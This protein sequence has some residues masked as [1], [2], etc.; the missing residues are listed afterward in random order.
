[1]QRD[2]C[3]AS[4]SGGAH[5]EPHSIAGLQW[6]VP[7]GREPHMLWV[8][9]TEDS[10]ALTQL[11]MTFSARKWSFYDPATRESPAGV[12]ASVSRALMR[13]YYLV[14]KA[15][16]AAI[17]GIL[18]GTLGVAGYL[19]VIDRLRA[20]ATA[21]GKK[22]YTMLMGKPSPTKLANFAEARPRGKG[23][24]EGLLRC[25][26]G[27]GSVSEREW[28]CVRAG[29]GLGAR[30]GRAGADIGLQGVSGAHRYAF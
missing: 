11:L 2:A 18:V 30:G 14:E 12:P 25:G 26:C 20:L 7:G 21:A 10:T 5:D 8:G 27:W 4:P 13:R 9:P 16:N 1:V 24:L 23:G 3:N 22:T 19:D 6:Q 17:V 29:R 15:K 28:P